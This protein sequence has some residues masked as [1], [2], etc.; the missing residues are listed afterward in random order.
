MRDQ[1]APYASESTEAKFSGGTGLGSSR[2]VKREAGDTDDAKFGLF[3]TPN[4]GVLLTTQVASTRKVYISPCALDTTCIQIS[5]GSNN[6]N[7]G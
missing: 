5:D 6:R 3:E 1:L 4:N 7:R 2:S